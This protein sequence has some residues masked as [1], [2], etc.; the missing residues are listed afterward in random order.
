MWSAVV[1]VSHMLGLVALPVAVLAI[2]E[3]G[4]LRRLSVPLVL[5][6]LFVAWGSLSFFWTVDVEATRKLVISWVQNLGMVWL[7]WELA[8]RRG[9][10]LVLMRTYVFGTMVSAGGTIYSYLTGSKV[11]YQRYTASGFDPNDLALLLALSLPISFYLTT[12]HRHSR[13]VWIYRLQLLAAIFAIGLTGSRG[14]LIATLVALAYLPFGSVK[15]TFRKKCAFLLVGV[16]AISFTLAFMP[17]ATWKRWRG[18]GGELE[19]GSWS[20]R[21]AIWSAG[22]ELVR[23]YPLQGV[24]AGGFRTATSS[25]LVAHNAFLSVLVEEGLVGFALFLL[26]IL[27]L[28][29]PALGL[30]TVERNLWLILLVTWVVGVSSLTWET[31]KA[32]WFL[33]GLAAARLADRSVN[34]GVRVPQPA[35]VTGTPST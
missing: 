29:L 30:P 22:L 13:L 33:F 25:P 27:S 1:T 24:G 10:Q 17:E 6:V 2:L 34:S 8:D 5:M 16:T 14:V 35:F 9:R 4:Q 18:M 12:I 21:K 26:L 20:G 32:T 31:K 23:E 15:M 11:H 7:I 28:T 19:Q 3:S